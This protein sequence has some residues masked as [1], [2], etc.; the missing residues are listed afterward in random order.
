M[1]SKRFE[2]K[3]VLITGGASGIGKATAERLGAE[4][5]AL[6]LADR[7]IEG[8][9]AVARAIAARHDARVAAVAFDAGQADSCRHAVDQAV[10]LTGRLDVLCNIAGITEFSHFMDFPDER[11][12]R[13]L[14]INL[15][16]LFYLCKQA[17]P[18]LI[19]NRGNIVNMASAAGLQGIAYVTAYCASK[20]GV[21]G[22]T[23][24]LAVEFASRRV[25]VN[26]IC[27]GGV[28]TPMND[29]N[30]QAIPADIETRLIERLYAKLGNGEMAEAEDIASMVA[31]LA[32]DDGVCQHSC[33]VK[34][35]QLFINSPPCPDSVS[36]PPAS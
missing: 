15:S 27:P 24:S 6:C 9:R 34:I 25:R 30:Q 8:A 14:R 19:E 22:L 2:G 4:G 23:K 28:N 5:A 3:S 36:L 31:Y 33:R 1:S 32:S 26:A 7:N 11:W 13:M 10:E 17:M 16:S 20:A 35:A 21:I 18:H 12:E 29:T